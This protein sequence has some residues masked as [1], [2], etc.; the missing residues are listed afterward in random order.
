MALVPGGR[1][2]AS[3]FREA[4]WVRPFL[5]DRFEVTVGAFRSFVESTGHRPE[6]PEAAGLWKQVFATGP[7]PGQPMVYVSLRDAE[8]YAHHL[9]KRLP[10]EAEW[11]AAAGGRKGFSYPWGQLFHRNRCNTVELGLRAATLVG[12]FESGRSEDGCYDLCGNVSEWTSTAVLSF[13]GK[14]EILEGYALRGQVVKGGSFGTGKK[15]A[16]ARAYSLEEPRNFS[17]VLGFRCAMDLDSSIVA[18]IVERLTSG[19]QEHRVLAAS[20]LGCLDPTVSGLPLRNALLGDKSERVRLAARE[21][22][23]RLRQ[24]AEPLAR[25]ALDSLLTEPMLRD[26]LGPEPEDV[27]LEPEPSAE[28]WED[29]NSLVPDWTDPIL[30]GEAGKEHEGTPPPRKDTDAPPGDGEPPR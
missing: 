12:T 28:S 19:T 18:R 25:E 22:L 20:R 13:P 7:D 9:G 3:P 26:L 11:E 14:D 8:A 2:R 4:V 6:D 29:P 24:D 5:L 30:E 16:Q 15:K 21:A 10:T 1:V 27:P 17:N 23:L